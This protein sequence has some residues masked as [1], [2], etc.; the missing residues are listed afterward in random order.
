MEPEV[1]Y[2]IHK[3]SP[4]VSVLSQIN[5]V[6]I[7]TFYFSKV[8]NIILLFYYFPLS[9]P[10]NSCMPYPSHFP[11]SDYFIFCEEQKLWRLSLWGFLQPSIISSLFDP[12][13]PLTLSSQIYFVISFLQ[14]KSTSFTLVQN[15]RHNFSYG[16]FNFYIHRLKTRCF[17]AVNFMMTNIAQIWS[18]PHF[19]S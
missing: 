8:G 18:F 16:Y 4:L 2:N 19:F 13:L 6:H 17:K 15:Y 7:T 10:P 1:Q 14:Y 9:F 12:A 3:I 5:A 11:W